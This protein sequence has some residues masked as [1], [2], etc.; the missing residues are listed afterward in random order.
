MPSWAMPSTTIPSCA[1]RPTADTG[2][3]VVLRTTNMTTI[4]RG[5]ASSA[6]GKEVTVYAA[7]W[8]AGV[9]EVSMGL[10]P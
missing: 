10:G 2:G 4:D 1:L 7:N 6:P 9:S 8:L 3:S 5:Q